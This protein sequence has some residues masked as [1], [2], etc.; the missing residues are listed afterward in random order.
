[1]SI[2]VYF[3]AGVLAQDCGIGLECRDVPGAQ[4]GRHRLD[5]RREFV[6]SS[7]GV[8]ARLSGVERASAQYIEEIDDPVF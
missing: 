3:P 5:V 2:G 4:Y 7:G 1:V 8:Q 6:P